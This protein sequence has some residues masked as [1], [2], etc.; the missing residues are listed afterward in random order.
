MGIVS[1][2]TTIV[3]AIRFLVLIEIIAAL[4]T[5][6]AD[7]VEHARGSFTSYTNIQIFMLIEQ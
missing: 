4:L 3:D 5:S 6:A 1:N 7:V 2:G